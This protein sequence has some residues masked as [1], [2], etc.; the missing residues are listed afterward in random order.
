M[1]DPTEAGH[2]PSNYSGF[3]QELL[4]VLSRFRDVAVDNHLSSG[5]L[6]GSGNNPL[7]NHHIKGVV[8]AATL[9]AH[10]ELPV[11]MS[12]PT[13]SGSSAR[14]IGADDTPYRF[15]VSAWV[16]DYDQAYGLEEAGVIIGNIID[17][18]ESNRNLESSPGAGDPLATDAG[19]DGGDSVTWDFA[20][21]VNDQVHLKWATADFVVETKRNIPR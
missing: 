19:L 21:N 10:Y 15:S 9:L 5:N 20:L 13:G 17:N 3:T 14:T 11:V 8:D 16:Q 12:I 18:V 6:D 7:V 1:V 2:D 4:Q